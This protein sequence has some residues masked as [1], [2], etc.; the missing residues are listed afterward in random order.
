MLELHQPYQ[1][2]QR[3]D[4]IEYR[5]YPAAIFAQVHVCG[6][7]ITRLNSGFRE[8][9]HY[10]SGGNTQLHTLTMH[11]PVVMQPYNTHEADVRIY[12]GGDAQHGDPPAPHSEAVAIMHQ[13]PAYMAAMIIDDA[14]SQTAL[15]ALATRL[16]H[17]L[18]Q[19]KL[20]DGALPEYRFYTLPWQPLGRSGEVVLRINRHPSATI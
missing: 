19:R 6:T 9:T 17:T 13:A 15:E 5:F 8:L 14:S 1:V 3:T 12:L 20:V 11:A 16:Q 18:H 7:H 10:I 4:D 2:I